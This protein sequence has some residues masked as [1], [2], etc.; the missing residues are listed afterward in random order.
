MAKRKKKFNPLTQP[1]ESKE[2]MNS[3]GWAVTCIRGKDAKNRQFHLPQYMNGKDFREWMIEMGEEVDD[4]REFR[5]WG[6][7]NHPDY[8]P[9][10]KLPDDINDVK[11]D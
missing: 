5:L 8:F 9:P 1:T 3:K 2:F 6:E 7:P 11:L 10:V 4:W